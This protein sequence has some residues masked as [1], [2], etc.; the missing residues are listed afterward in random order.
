MFAISCTDGTYRFISKSGREEKKISAHEGAVIIVDWSH[1]GSALLSA[2]EDGDLK[3]WSKS[4]NLRSTLLSVGQSLFAACWGPG[5]TNI[6]VANGKQLIVKYIDDNKKTRQWNAHDAT[7]LCVDWNVSNSLIISGA[8]DCTYRVWDQFGRQLFSSRPMEQVITSISWSPNGENFAVG[9]FNIVRLCDKSGWTHCREKHTNGSLMDIMWTSDGTQF[10]GACSDGSVMLAQVVDRKIEWKNI[11]VTLLESRKIRVQ[12][13]ANESLEDIEYARDRV[14]EMG[15]GFDHL[16]VTTSTQCYI[17]G[18]QNLNT[19]II[20]DIK[21]P[22]HFLHLCRTHFLTLDLV[23]GLQ[24]ISYEGRTLC[25]PKFQGLRAEY[26]TRD[27]VALCP[28]CVGIVDTVDAK[29]V[30]ILDATTARPLARIAH[31]CEIIGLQFNQHS[32]GIQERIIAV[33]DKNRDFFIASLNGGAFGMAQAN[34]VLT[35]RKLH[36]HVES[37]VFN[38]ETDV[39]VGT[40]D[41]RLNIWYAPMVAFLDKDLLVQTTLS[42]DASDLGRNANITSYTGNRITIRKV[43]GSVLYSS[44]S[45]DIPLLYELCR[46]G[47]WDESIRLCRHQKN[48]ALWGILA[49]FALNKKHLDTAETALCELN[50]VAKV[51]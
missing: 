9:S 29:N 25:S 2:G 19:P 16:V 33:V 49:T 28:D 3:I 15:I 5:D 36:S 22:T 48:N 46:G 42:M 23:A 8:E 45:V 7:I 18:L 10:A 14:V 41:G 1:D 12:D 38:D 24:I 43:D 31:T 26:L 44:T 40:S 17:Y 30:Q 39:V 50:E 13:T 32:L 21:A 37:F 27:M 47:R 51:G 34:Q 35:L 11:E 6:L 4:G 20:F